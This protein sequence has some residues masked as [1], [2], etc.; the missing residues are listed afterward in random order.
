L[1]RALEALASL[2]KAGFS[3]GDARRQNLLICSGKLKWCDLQFAL[4]ISDMGQETTTRMFSEDISTLMQSFGQALHCIQ[5]DEDLLKKYVSDVST[6]NLQ[7]LVA[8][9]EAGEP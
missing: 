4:D 9:S 7:A 8:E 6:E 5:L 2:H 1:H 3:H